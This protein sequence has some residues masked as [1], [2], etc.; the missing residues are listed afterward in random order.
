M[1]LS[2]SLCLLLYVPQLPVSSSFNK[3]LGRFNGL[4]IIRIIMCIIGWA[5]VSRVGLLACPQHR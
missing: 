1:T 3:R 5:L 2:H 4:N